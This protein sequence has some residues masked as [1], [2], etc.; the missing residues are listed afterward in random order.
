[1]LVYFRK[2]TKGGKRKKGEEEEE[3]HSRLS[4][5]LLDSCHL[6]I[7]STKMPSEELAGVP[8]GMRRIS[9]SKPG[10]RTEDSPYTG[11]DDI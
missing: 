2:S 1:M 7:F 9:V 4:C 8:L 11:L 5:V 6:G 3:H 10:R